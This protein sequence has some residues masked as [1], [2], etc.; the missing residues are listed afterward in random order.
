MRYSNSVARTLITFIF[1][2]SLLSSA[3][4][5]AQKTGELAPPKVNHVN[6]HWVNIASNRVQPMVDDVSIGGDYGLTHVTSTYT[7]DFANYF[8]GSD[9]YI[10]GPNDNFRG[11]LY[12]TLLHKNCDT[13]VG[14]G[15]LNCETIDT[16]WTYKLVVVGPNQSSS[17]TVLDGGVYRPLGDQNDWLEYVQIAGFTGYKYTSSDGTELYFPS[18]RKVL[19]ME[20]IKQ[21]VFRAGLTKI[22]YPDAR[23]V[24]ID[25]KG[26]ST[27]VVGSVPIDGS[28]SSVTT[29]TGFQLK[30]FYEDD[31]R[32]IPSDLLNPEN[33][34]VEHIAIMN[35]DN[36]QPKSI[37]GVNNSVDYCARSA[38]SVGECA[39]SQDWPHAEYLW[40]VGMPR[41]MYAGDSEFHLVTDSG[42]N[43]R[44]A[45][46]PYERIGA[47]YPRIVQIDKNDLLVAKYTHEYR[48]FDQT[49]SGCSGSMCAVFSYAIGTPDLV[50]S[51]RGDDSIG[52]Y[53]A[54][55]TLY[56]DVGFGATGYPHNDYV[57][58]DASGLTW[59]ID[60][61]ERTLNYSHQRNIDQSEDSWRHPQQ[62]NRVENEVRKI[63]FGEVTYSYDDRGN[64]T[65]KN[66]AGLIWKASYPVTCTNR[67]T[68]NKPEWIE[69][70][71]GN[72][73]DFTYHAESGLVASVTK[74]TDKNGVRPQQR[75][76]YVQ[77]YAHFKQNGD[78]VEQAD[79]PVWVRE[80][81]SY[82][83]NSAFLDGVCAAN[84]EVTI[85]YEYSHYNLLPIGNVITADGKSLRT[86]IARDVYGNEIGQ[87]PPNLTQGHTTCAD[88][89]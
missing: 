72:R 25:W 16:V 30:Y 5:L 2:C 3:S 22:V 69:D 18:T 46:K 8:D 80:S 61:L 83:R 31:S 49:N 56:N 88:F 12:S 20:D 47:I 17:F 40:P 28:I 76:E 7:S 66:D 13:M 44:F 51:E 43:Y 32:V 45:L 67:K 29:N 53:V 60:L 71:R 70:P 52:Y 63:G 89:Q 77:K 57:Q 9:P 42:D 35:W 82:C 24:T 19:K 4:V 15:V 78:Q 39:F 41:A 21:N 59:Y 23:E 85:H 27:P 1:C 34:L 54:R 84:D 58:M 86:C 33:Q 87:Y 36:Y 62:I 26:V 81:E 79:K 38:V 75:F 65:E 68:C 14:N 11:G 37:Y 48:Q 74:P 6:R 64:V 50:T 10:I 55:R 73:T